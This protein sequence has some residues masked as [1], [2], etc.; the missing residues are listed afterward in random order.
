MFTNIENIEIISTYRY[1]SKKPFVEVDC[2]L[3]NAFLIRI[4][5]SRLYNFGNKKII[6]NPGDLVFVPQ[7]SSY[8]SKALSDSSVYFAINFKADFLQPTQPICYSMENFYET[9]FITN[10]FADL[11]NIGTQADRYQCMSLFYSLLSYL[12][13]VEIDTDH[14]NSKFKMIDPAVEYLKGHIYDSKLTTDKLHRLCGISNTYFRQ[15]FLERFGTNP[16]NYIL[17]KRLSH[18]KAIITS[19]EYNTISEVALSIGFNDPLYFSKVFKKTYGISP[20]EI[21]EDKL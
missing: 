19:C 3:D 13:S 2:R 12:C 7:G 16:K 14:R 8:N 11:W 10:K 4:E 15:I 20:S 9:E 5:G 1:Y 6:A 18:A 21:N 17:S